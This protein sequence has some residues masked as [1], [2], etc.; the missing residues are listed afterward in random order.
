MNCC[1]KKGI[2]G[3]DEESGA[4]LFAL[5]PVSLLAEIK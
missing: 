2:D 3:L 5:L 4:S 1:V